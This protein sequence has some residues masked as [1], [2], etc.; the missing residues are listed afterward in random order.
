MVRNFSK[1]VGAYKHFSSPPVSSF[2]L[3]FLYGSPLFISAPLHSLLNAPQHELCSHRTFITEV[4][5]HSSSFIL[6]LLVLHLL[7][8]LLLP[9]ATEW[10][11]LTSFTHSGG[12][13]LFPYFHID[14]NTFLCP[15]DYASLLNMIT[16]SGESYRMCVT[17]KHRHWR[18]LGL[19]LAVAPQQEN[20]KHICQTTAVHPSFI[21]FPF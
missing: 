9:L 13:N 7:L 4:P 2:L 3:L 20:N 6:V 16:C 12:P 18:G 21:P 19:S 14:T 5:I 17:Y 11:D 15:L 8:F 10:L 1:K